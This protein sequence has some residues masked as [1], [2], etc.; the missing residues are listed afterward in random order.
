VI[1]ILSSYAGTKKYNAVHRLQTSFSRENF[2]NNYIIAVDKNGR[3]AKKRD[4]SVKVGASEIAESKL[5][6]VWNNECS[7]Y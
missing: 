2:D 1:F 3:N 7:T 6:E 4:G 5:A